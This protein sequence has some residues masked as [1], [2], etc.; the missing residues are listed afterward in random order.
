M[1]HGTS[2]IIYIW[3]HLKAFEYGRP[4]A[5]Q[6]AAAMGSAG[7]SMGGFK[8]AWDAAPDA[9]L[10]AIEAT[11]DISEDAAFAGPCSIALTRASRVFI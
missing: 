8:T 11:A 4:S 9:E 1:P 5:L 10:L 7:G 2:E 3:S 6:A